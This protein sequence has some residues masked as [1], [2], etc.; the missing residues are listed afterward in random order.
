MVHN[1]Q[2]AIPNGATVLGKT[3]TFACRILDFPGRA[4]A[5][6]SDLASP[7]TP[8]ILHEFILSTLLFQ[9]Q[10]VLF[11]KR[12]M[13]WGESDVSLI[14]VYRYTFVIHSPEYKKFTQRSHSV[15][16]FGKPVALKVRPLFCCYCTCI[17]ETS[18]AF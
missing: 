5:K 18:V 10:L 1:I 17:W 7:I 12:C 8:M 16:F 14:I 13:P 4:A 6:H 9:P 2:N 11:A 3:Q 15:E